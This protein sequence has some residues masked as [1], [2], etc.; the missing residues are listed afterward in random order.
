MTA[1]SQLATTRATGSGMNVPTA[2]Q[3]A[4]LSW[5]RL[6]CSVDTRFATHSST[7]PLDK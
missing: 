5:E 1:I 2:D 7:P 4:S 3:N 6:E